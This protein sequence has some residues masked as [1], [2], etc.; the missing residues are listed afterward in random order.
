M[1]DCAHKKHKPHPFQKFCYF[2]WKIDF[3]GYFALKIVCRDN[4]HDLRTLVYVVSYGKKDQYL[5]TSGTQK[6]WFQ[7]KVYQN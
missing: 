6:Y 2:S 1:H 3:F 5:H 4:N 7:K